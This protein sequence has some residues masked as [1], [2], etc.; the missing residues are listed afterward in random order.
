MDILFCDLCNESVPQ[1]DLDLGWAQRR[2]GRIICARCDAAMSA[3]GAEAPGS[4]G[5]SG[6]SPGGTATAVAASP[7]AAA[8]APAPA[9]P[10][11]HAGAH[12]PRRRGSG[13]ANP[14]GVMVG[15]AAIVFA[16]GGSALILDQVE[17]EVEGAA[18]ARAQLALG[19]AEQSRALLRL[20]ETMIVRIGDAED[21]IHARGEP[22]RQELRASLASLD[23][24]LGG[25]RDLVVSLGQ[26]IDALRAAT[27]AEDTRARNDIERVTTLAERMDEDL[28]FFRDEL[29][30]LEENMRGLAVRGAPRLAYPTG[31]PTD[32]AEG[33][34]AGPAWAPLLGD[35]E[36][37][38]AAIR[39][40]AI[41]GLAETKDAQ[42]V[43]HLVPMLDDSDLFVRMAT[44]R[45][46]QNLGAKPAVPAL[47]DALEDSESAVMEAAMLALRDITQR[48]F[49]FDPIASEAERAKRVKAWRD[50]WKKEGDAFLAG[51]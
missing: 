40:E 48:N 2:A 12:A 26:D 15:L 16:G 49:R 25:A 11:P 24:R 51:G 22:W 35:L 39:L 36:H 44:A 29:I 46:L 28:R 14:A 9:G 43:P 50:W 8:S 3:E 10:E 38:S 27:S 21:A 37:A 23:E 17:G 42:V 20:D 13:A 41:Y 30:R 31:T 4:P 45:T 47:I 1:A 18:E 5:G 34:D 33:E 7:R 6:G 32:S 19:L